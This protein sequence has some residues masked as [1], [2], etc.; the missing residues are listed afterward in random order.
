MDGVGSS[1]IKP[2]AKATEISKVHT[3]KVTL[4]ILRLSLGSCVRRCLF[5]VLMRSSREEFTQWKVHRRPRWR[6]SGGP[7]L[8]ISCRMERVLLAPG[9]RV[10]MK[11]FRLYFPC[12]AVYVGSPISWL[13][14]AKCWPGKLAPLFISTHSSLLSRKWGSWVEARGIQWMNSSRNLP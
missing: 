6:H 11:R 3:P 7:P 5:S 4:K 14:G 13:Q 10:R 8:G 2:W 12:P 1:L 9:Q